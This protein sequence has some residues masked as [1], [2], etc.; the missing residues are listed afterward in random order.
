[1]G[2][3]KDFAAGGGEAFNRALGSGRK[4]RDV[5]DDSV[6]RRGKRQ[7]NNG[8]PQPSMD[9]QQSIGQIRPTFNKA[10]ETMERNAG[11]IPRM[12]SSK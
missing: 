1:M 7:S 9:P 4:R 5:D 3:S 12:G 11:N 6:I 2:F 10:K 8:P